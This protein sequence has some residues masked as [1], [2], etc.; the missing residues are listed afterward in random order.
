M[1]TSGRGSCRSLLPTAERCGMLSW[2]SLSSRMCATCLCRV[3]RVCDR[4]CACVL[5]T[6]A[7]P[8]CLRRAAR[9]WCASVCVRASLH[10]LG[11]WRVRLVCVLRACTCARVMVSI[12]QTSATCSC[13][14]SAASKCLCARPCWRLCASSV[15]LC[16]NWASAA[17]SQHE[18]WLC[19]YTRAMRL[20]LHTS[21]ACVCC[22]LS[23]V[24][25]L[26][27]RTA[28]TC[29]R[30]HPQSRLPHLLDDNTTNQQLQQHAM[31]CALHW[32]WC[33][34]S[35]TD[36]VGVEK[37]AIEE[38]CCHRDSQRIGQDRVF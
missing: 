16:P 8:L 30:T 11:S 17:R 1:A 25:W 36:Q 5:S 2:L 18:F 9:V 27:V 12:G 22:L 15:R 29:T 3:R 14:D 19:V 31:P 26:L 13:A 28:R 24:P 35:C 38:H 6:A 34:C 37:D 4:V 10:V 23:C 21:M 33:L 20:A 32:W 7:R